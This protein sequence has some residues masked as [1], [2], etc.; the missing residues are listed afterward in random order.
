MI[1]L[2]GLK[3]PRKNLVQD[4]VFEIEMELRALPLEQPVQ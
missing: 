2:E 1:C 3:K 4:T